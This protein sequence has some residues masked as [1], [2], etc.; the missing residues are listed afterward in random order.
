[1]AIP[2]HGK[3]AA[4]RARSIEEAQ[5]RLRMGDLNGA[6]EQVEPLLR[7][8]KNDPA[9]LL[10]AGLIAERRRRVKDATAYA[11]RSLKIQPHP[12]AHLLLARCLRLSGDTEEAIRHCDDVLRAHP[13][14]T[15]TLV[16]KGGALEEAGRFDEARQIIEPLHERG[17]GRETPQVTFEW[18]KLLVHSREYAEAIE[19]LD[20]VIE[21]DRTLDDAKRLYLHLKAKACDRSGDFVGAFETAERSN[22]IGRLEFS[23]ELYEEQVTVL[24]DN[25]SR[26]KMNRFP[27]SSC[28][29]DVPVFV[30]GMP[31]SGTSLIDQIIDAHPKASGVGELATIEQFAIK[32]ASVWNPD[33]EPPEC[34]GR[35]DRFRWTRAAREYLGEVSKLA[36]T[37]DRIVNK[38]LGNNKLVG[39]IARL[40]PNTRII[41]AIR[42]PR[43]VA[44]S[45]FMGGFNNALHPWTTRPEWVARAWEQSMRMMEHWKRSLDVPILDV[46]YEKLVREPGTEFPRIIEFLGLEW[47]DACREFHRSRRTVRTLSYDQVNRP[48]YTTSVGRHVNYA[49]FLEGI[50]FPEYDSGLDDAGSM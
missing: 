2:K 31:R 24:I 38:A 13:Q 50:E 12:E 3:V 32:L 41:H 17:L 18:C 45:C 37:A 40:F 15:M 26:E 27:V 36:P 29:S 39:L 48:L 28:D 5:A 33:K 46:K 1:M 44:V 4:R 43:D 25:W 8:D 9:A 7:R 49:R 14:H 34:F 30:A 11:R 10:L 35:F 22:A 19:L 47:D 20:E 16:V 42:D 23:P 21:H 6:S